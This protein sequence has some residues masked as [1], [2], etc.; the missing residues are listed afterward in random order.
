MKLFSHFNPRQH[1]ETRKFSIPYNARL[2]THFTENLCYPHR[3]LTPAA[4]T[5]SDPA[6]ESPP[7]PP[8]LPSLPPPPPSRKRS[9][10]TSTRTRT[11]AG[12]R[13]TAAPAEIAGAGEEVSRRQRYPPPP[14]PATASTSD[15]FT[16]DLFYLRQ[17]R[18]FGK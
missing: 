10:C 6:V 11:K 15:H 3:R 1:Q 4:A 9:A 5:A 2:H 18:H 16:T 8:P 17:A 13:K 14:G 7:P 12:S